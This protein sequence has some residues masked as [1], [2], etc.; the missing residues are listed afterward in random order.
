MRLRLHAR[1]IIRRL[2]HADVWFDYC[3]RRLRT[4]NEPYNRTWLNERQLELAVAFDFLDRLPP[5]AVGL[6]VGNVLA[7]YRRVTHH[8]VDK[9]ERAPAVDNIDVVDLPGGRRY[10]Y[11]V[12]ISTLE[13]AGRDESP[14]DHGKSAH[15]VRHLR[16][17]LRPGGTLLLTVPVGYNDALDAAVLSL[18]VCA[19][20]TYAL[21]RTWRWRRR[22][23]TERD[24]RYHYELRCAQAVWIGEIP[25][26]LGAD[27]PSGSL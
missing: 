10:D 12:A 2:R 11:I 20:E 3:G 6:E 24:F 5:G 4:V 18:P 25:Y 16:S 23:V 15:A 19:K 7:H 22:P 21:D 27:G 1:E 17:L 26:G 14:R 13:H 8:V 9:Y